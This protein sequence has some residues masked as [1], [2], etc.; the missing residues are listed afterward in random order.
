MNAGKFSITA[1]TAS[2]VATA[3]NFR[4]NKVLPHPNNFG[5][6]TKGLYLFL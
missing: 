1:I 2:Y 4:V 5:T 3:V 6:S